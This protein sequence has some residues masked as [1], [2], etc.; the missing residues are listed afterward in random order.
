MVFVLTPAAY[1]L[2]RS[3]ALRTADCLAIL[4]L[5]LP[6]P[7]VATYWQLRNAYGRGRL[8]SLTLTHGCLARPFRDFVIFKRL[9]I[10]REDPYK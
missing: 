6:Y 2:P 3:L 5:L 7:G 10:G 9:L 8:D 1:A 4:L